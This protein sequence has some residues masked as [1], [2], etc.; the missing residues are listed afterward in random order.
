LFLNELPGFQ[1]LPVSFRGVLRISSSLPISA[2]GLRGQYNERGD[3]LIS[4]TPALADNAPPVSG[5]LVFPHI[6]TGG[7]YTTEFLLLNRGGASAGTLS[8]RSQSGAE[9]A[10]P[11]RR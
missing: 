11:I 2:I 8:L 3:F 10:L 9:L 5:E 7:G 4:T 6:A 1:N